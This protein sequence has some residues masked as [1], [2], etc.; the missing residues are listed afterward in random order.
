MMNSWIIYSQRREAA[1]IQLFLLAHAG[2]GSAAFRGW[3]G[4]VGDKIELGYVQLPGHDSR[5]MEQPCSSIEEL[6]PQLVDALGAHI[7]RPFAFYGHS[8]G[9]KIAFE[10][11]RELRNRGASGPAHLFV[12]ACQAPQLPWPHPPMNGLEA[13]HF[14]S[15]VQERYGSIP[16]QV[17]EDEELCSLLLPALRADV[18]MVETYVYTAGAPLYCGITA[19]GGLQDQTVSQSSLEQWRTQTSGE[20]HLRMMP[21]NHFFPQSAESR[22]PEFIAAELIDIVETHRHEEHDRQ[23]RGI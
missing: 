6:I 21:G 18:R 7:N 1:S 22:I 4:R 15:Q 9:A 20:F 17:V 10:A 14:L 12:A 19:F 13:S 3:N 8:L 23:L 5:L 11:A 16:R 2:G